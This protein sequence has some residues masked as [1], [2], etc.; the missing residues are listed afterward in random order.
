MLWIPEKSV[1]LYAKVEH[2]GN[3]FTFNNV[4]YVLPGEGKATT[5]SAVV[6]RIR[7]NAIYRALCRLRFLLGKS[8]KEGHKWE[9][10]LQYRGRP[11]NQTFIPS[12]FLALA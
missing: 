4:V 11:S 1:Q 8:L 2:L 9:V 3:D 5:F 10:N 12:Y 6:W 7:G